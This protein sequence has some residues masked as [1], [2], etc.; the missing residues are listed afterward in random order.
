MEILLIA[1]MLAY[2]AGA[3]SEQSKLGLSPAQRAVM[4][5]Q[6]RHEKAVQRIREKH[7]GAAPPAN[8]TS[9]WKNPPGVD[10]KTEAPETFWSGYRTQ[11]PA[12]PPLGHRAGTWAGNGVSW[13]Q[14]TGREAWRAY[15]K[16]R[17]D[18]GDRDPSL[19]VAP[20][21]PQYPPMPAQP[22]TVGGDKTSAA[23]KPDEK[24]AAKPG[25]APKEGPAAGLKKAPEPT[26]EAA[27]ETGTAPAAE[28]TP[29]TP[30]PADTPQ[31]VGRMAAEVTYD[32]VME[33]SDELSAM[34]GDDL[35]TYDR[36]EKRAE[37]E[38][39]RGDTLAAQVRSTGF[40]QTISA[41]VTRCTE[42]YRVIHGAID[43]LKQNTIAQAEA[44]VTA[45]D[46]L[47]RGQGVYAGIAKDMEDVAEREAY[48]SDAVDAEDTNPEAEHYETKAA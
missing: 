45:K 47:E 13:A 20:A 37:R 23:V 31:G 5:E 25:E 32:S 9:P 34:C 40:G 33:E 1:C 7:G 26:P 27:K 48:I 16:R 41:L 42:Q 10:P 38:I 44:V 3:Q 18:A 24:P 28:T 15:R 29:P 43:D 39:G 11:R 17:K 14:E 46:L 6:T 8:G 4:R 19:I 30:Q 35:H 2:T 21:Q 36:I 12:R 22:P